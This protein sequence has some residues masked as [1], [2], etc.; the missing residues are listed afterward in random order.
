MWL[1][2]D[3]SVSC[4]VW[5]LLHLNLPSKHEGCNIIDMQDWAFWNILPNGSYQTTIACYLELHE[6]DYKSNI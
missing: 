1:H 2:A 5:L 3:E 6:E 4:L